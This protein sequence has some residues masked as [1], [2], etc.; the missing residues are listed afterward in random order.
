MPN[1]KIK[2]S[3][4]MFTDIVGYSKKIQNASSHASGIYFVK[5]QAGE[6]VNTQKRMLAK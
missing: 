4:I 2:L 5:M 6:F 1:A 3:S